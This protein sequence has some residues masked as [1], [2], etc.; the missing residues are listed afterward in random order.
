LLICKVL[1]V[2]KISLRDA[3]SVA[4]KRAGLNGASLQCRLLLRILQILCRD[5]LA[6]DILQIR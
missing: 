4:S 1:L 2:C 6:H 3:R 5:L